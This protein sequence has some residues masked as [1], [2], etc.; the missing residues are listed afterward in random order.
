M[1]EQRGLER[2]S[3]MLADARKRTLELVSDLSEE[4]MLGPKLKIV[5]PPLWEIGHLAWFQER[6]NL[7]RKEENCGFSFGPSILHNADELYDSMEV[8]HDT[9]WGLPLLSREDTLSYMRRVLDDTLRKL[10]A[11]GPTVD[12][13]YFAR[14][15]IFHEDMHAEAFTYTRNTHGLTPPPISGHD[16]ALLEG[17]PTGDLEGDVKIP[18]GTFMLGATRDLPFVFDN[19]K[20]AHPVEIAPFEMAHAPVTN[21]GFAAFVDDEGYRRR[22]LW[23]EEG[24]GWRESVSADHPVYWWRAGDG[25]WLRRHFDRIEPLPPHQP[26]VHVNW[27]EAEA[28]CRWA[29]RRLPTEAEWE[30]AA[31]AEPGGRSVVPR[32]RVYPWGDEPAGPDLANLDGLLLGPVDVAAFPGGESAFGCRQMMGNVWEWC[33]DAFGPYPGFVPDPYDDY[34]EPWFGDHRVQ[35]GGSWATRSRMLR[36]TWRNFAMP[37]RRDVFAGFRTCAL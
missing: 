8:A 13:A 2:L 20:W 4:Q 22:D 11:E 33:A 6:W 32:K 31:S 23:S 5:N 24:W 28:Y 29:G 15:A 19:E 27:H 1:S 26:V 16:P 9:R 30:L 18:G 10:E 25:T 35:R 34:S 36:N 17:Q 21:A 3:G 37:D 7:R 14:L 12:A